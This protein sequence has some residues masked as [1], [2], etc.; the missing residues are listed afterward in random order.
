MI[1]RYGNIEENETYI[2]ATALDPRYKTRIFRNNNTSKKVT[3]LLYSAIT[4]EK[5]NIATSVSS[6][7]RPSTSINN[8]RQ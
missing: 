5:T 1:Y 4:E 3:E 8:R 6:P 2:L 7:N